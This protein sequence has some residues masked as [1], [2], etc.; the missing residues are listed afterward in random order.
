MH[1]YCFVSLVVLLRPEKDIYLQILYANALPRAELGDIYRHFA[2]F[3]LMAK[4][5]FPAT[6]SRKG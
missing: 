5:E 3:P 6:S 2:K 4:A 1:S